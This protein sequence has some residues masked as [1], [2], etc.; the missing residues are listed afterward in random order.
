MKYE[1]KVINVIGL[2][3]LIATI[4][5]VAVEAEKGVNNINW[6]HTEVYEFTNKNIDWL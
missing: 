3:I 1:S 4:I 6:K 2:I 5:F